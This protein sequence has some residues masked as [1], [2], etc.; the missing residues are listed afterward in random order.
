MLKTM[1]D[2]RIQSTKAHIH[3]SLH[4]SKGE[5]GSK[6]RGNHTK[7]FTCIESL[8]IPALC[9]D[10]T[11]RM[12]TTGTNLLAGGDQESSIFCLVRKFSA[13]LSTCVAIS[14]LSMKLETLITRSIAKF[15]CNQIKTYRYIYIT[16]YQM[17]DFK[18]QKK[19][20]TINEVIEVNNA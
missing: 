9:L 1:Q 3:K 10:I 2:I 7:S 20:F 19:G 5:L 13:I 4:R 15:S 11:N 16:I 17:S 14:F 8:Y 12:R 6:E 18:N